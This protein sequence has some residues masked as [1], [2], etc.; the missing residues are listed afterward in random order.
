MFIIVICLLVG[1]NVCD[2]ELFLF[3]IER[4]LGVNVGGGR[5]GG[6]VFLVI[7]CLLND[8]R[9]GVGGVVLVF[10][11]FLYICVFFLDVGLVGLVVV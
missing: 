7:C 2:L 9:E 8:F 4:F 5:G 1:I 6:D 10:D 11:F 3:F